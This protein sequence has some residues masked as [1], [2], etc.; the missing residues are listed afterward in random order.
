MSGL[1]TLVHAPLA[2]KEEAYDV[3]REKKKKRLS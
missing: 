3:T 2:I 1:S